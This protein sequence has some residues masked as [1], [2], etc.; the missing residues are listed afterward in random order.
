M[1]LSWKYNLAHKFNQYITQL[2]ESTFR[3]VQ[4]AIFELQ[5]LLF[6]HLFGAEELII[7]FELI[8]YR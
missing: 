2:R 1:L 7:W 8:Q 3:Q 5:N 4:F 6:F